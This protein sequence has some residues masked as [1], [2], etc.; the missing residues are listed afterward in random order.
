MIFLETMFGYRLY[1]NT[2]YRDISGMHSQQGGRAGPL[3]NTETQPLVTTEN[4]R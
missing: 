2:S 3:D 4:L 1:N